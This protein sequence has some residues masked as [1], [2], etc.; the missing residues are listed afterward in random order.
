MSAAEKDLQS[1]IC[2]E[3]DLDWQ[4]LGMTFDGFQ[5]NHILAS[6]VHKFQQ[7]DDDFR[8][9]KS[10]DGRST[11]T[12]ASGLAPKPE[13]EIEPFFEMEDFNSGNASKKLKLTSK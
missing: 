10:F 3:P 12:T 7:I 4:A 2:D 13:M 8:K 5:Q 1:T 11:K 6:L 9:K